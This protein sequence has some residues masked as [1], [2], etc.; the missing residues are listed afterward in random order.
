[1]V[2]APGP[3]FNA[4]MP[5]TAPPALLEQARDSVRG[6]TAP[7]EATARRVAARLGINAPRAAA[8]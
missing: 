5:E 4:G 8:E 3:P 2:Y 6:I 1:M 7:R